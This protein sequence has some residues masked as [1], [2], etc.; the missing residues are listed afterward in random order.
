M[1][2]AILHSTFCGFLGF[3]KEFDSAP[4]LDKLDEREEEQGSG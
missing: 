1:S 4:P 3:F 2:V